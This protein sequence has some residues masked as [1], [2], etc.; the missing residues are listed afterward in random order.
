MRNGMRPNNKYA[1]A[2]P[3]IT[4]LSA[5]G[6]RRVQTTPEGLQALVQL[7]DGDMRRVLNLLQ[8]RWC[9]WWVEGLARCCGRRS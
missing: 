5:R 6:S 4:R 9:V 1:R 7:S 8:V 2:A 3:L